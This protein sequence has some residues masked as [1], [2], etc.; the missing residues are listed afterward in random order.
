VIV[1]SER[2]EETVEILRVNGLDAVDPRDQDSRGLGADLVVLGAEGAN[3]LEFDA[4]VVVEPATIASRGARDHSSVT[5]R[6]LRTLYVAMTRPT[7]RLAIVASKA[8]PETL[9]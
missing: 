3:G 2:I 9:G 8:L 7:R 6:G 4:V 1:A 5:P